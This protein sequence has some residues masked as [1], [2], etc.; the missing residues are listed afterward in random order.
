MTAAGAGGQAGAR[1]RRLAGLDLALEASV[2]VWMRGGWWALMRAD[3]RRRARMRHG[4]RR[5][6]GAGRSRPWRAAIGGGT[7]DL[8]VCEMAVR[9]TAVV[10]ARCSRPWFLINGLERYGW[11]AGQSEV[12]QESCAARAAG[13][14]MVGRRVGRRMGRD[15]VVVSGRANGGARGGP[16]GWSCRSRKKN[17]EKKCRSQSRSGRAEVM[18]GWVAKKRGPGAQC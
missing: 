4:C 1:R 18:G 7:A 5:H 14:S 17:G 12:R 13:G 11:R 2:H 16:V 6:G 10:Q 3:A 15:V 8:H 9:Q